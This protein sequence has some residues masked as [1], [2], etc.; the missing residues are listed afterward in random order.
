VHSA[1]WLGRRVEANRGWALGY[2]VGVFFVLPGAVLASEQ[3]LERTRPSL[4]EA[5]ATDDAGAALTD[6]VI[7]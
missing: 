2:V 7:E 5:T 6:L 3:L 4:L 1:H